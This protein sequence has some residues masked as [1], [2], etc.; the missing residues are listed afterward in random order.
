MKINKAIIWSL[1]LLII[2]AA[3]YRVFPNRPL[4]FAPQLAMAL[5]AGATIKDKKWAFAVPIFS[6]FI[7]DL[8]YQLLYINGLSDIPGFYEG[9]LTNY[10]LFLAVTCIGFLLKNVTVLSVLAYSLVA[11]TVFFLASNFLLWV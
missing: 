11:P 4:G 5:Y 7:S 10:I 9:Q 1:V 8:L 2:V 3:V 6:M